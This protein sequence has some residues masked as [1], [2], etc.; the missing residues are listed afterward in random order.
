MTQE[1]LKTFLEKAKS[2]HSLQE[3]LKAAGDANA[4]VEIAKAAG[5]SI[6]A[7]DLTKAQSELSREELEGMAGGVDLFSIVA[8]TPLCILGRDLNS[9]LCNM[10]WKKIF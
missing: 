9:G 5:F 10:P 1:Q 7:D 6:S 4:V 2:N 3:K 8:R